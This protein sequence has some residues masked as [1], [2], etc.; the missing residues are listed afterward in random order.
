MRQFTFYWLG[1]STEVGT[2]TNVATAF[3]SLGYGDVAIC[4]LHY[5]LECTGEEV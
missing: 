4:G 2:G 3:M 1:G 5:Y